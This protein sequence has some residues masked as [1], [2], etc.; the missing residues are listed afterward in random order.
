MEQDE[1]LCHKL[2][3]IQMST[4][5]TLRQTLEEEQACQ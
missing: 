5:A 2:R 1:D 3:Q 4:A